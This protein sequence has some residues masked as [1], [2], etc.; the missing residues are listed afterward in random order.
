MI[1]AIGYISLALAIAFWMRRPSLDATSV[2]L[3]YMTASIGVT[4][5]AA[6]Y[7]GAASSSLVMDI[8]SDLADVLFAVMCVA[9][10]IIVIIANVSSRAGG[11][12]KESSPPR[13]ARAARSLAVASIILSVLFVLIMSRIYGGVSEFVFRMFARV[14]LFNSVANFTLLLNWGSIVLSAFAFNF[15]PRVRPN[16]TTALVFISVFLSALV[17]L[18][19]GGR[20]VLLLYI[21]SIAFRYIIRLSSTKFI[22]FG[23]L[24]VVAT[25]FV[26]SLLIT[27]RYEAQDAAILQDSEEDSVFVRGVTGLAYL[28]H[29]VLAHEYANAHG[30]DLGQLYFNVL[31]FPIPR[32][33]WPGKPLLISSLVRQYRYGDV[34]GGT[35]PGLFGE[36]YIAFGYWGIALVVPLLGF[37]LGKVDRLVRLAR[38]TD[39]PYQ[40][41][42]AGIVVPLVG[43]ALIRGGVD[44]GATRVGAPLAW[45]FVAWLLISRSRAPKLARHSHGETAR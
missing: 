44:V 13:N 5:A 29:M 23:F 1:A 6:N 4:H 42:L 17:A 18:S 32:D 31:T 27:A 14:Q 35:P 10:F 43:F 12:I 41:A 11:K 45:C 34:T 9:I 7:F 40:T 22:L 39:S 33:L 25:L 20:S 2:F 28:D 3:T 16:A 38:S 37:V 19:S 24:M 26:S 30:H 36:A 15:L 21:V 8:T